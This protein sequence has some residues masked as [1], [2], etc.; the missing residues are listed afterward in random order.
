MNNKNYKGKQLKLTAIHIN[1]GKIEN[2]I[3]RPS[4]YGT[5]MIW[6]AIDIQGQLDLTGQ[7]YT[8]EEFLTLWTF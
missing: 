2:L 8:L 6:S 4:I 1:T 3:I 7:H 5:G